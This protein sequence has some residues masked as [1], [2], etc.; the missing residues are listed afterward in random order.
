MRQL[1]KTGL[2]YFIN[3]TF[4]FSLTACFDAERNNPFD[5]KSDTYNGGGTGGVL[6][7]EWIQVS[8]A[9]VD[10]GDVAINDAIGASETITIT[11]ISA[12]G[13][14]LVIN[15]MT[16]DNS[17]GT[18]FTHNAALTATSIEPG[19]SESFDVN[20]APITAG[21]FSA[22]LIINSND[23]ALPAAEI[24]MKG[25]GI[26]GPSFTGSF[27]INPT[28]LNF[29]DTVAGVTSAQIQIQIN[30]TT[31]SNITIDSSV[32]AGSAF[33]PN[34]VSMGIPANG[35]IVIFVTFTPPAADYY[36]DYLTLT[37]NGDPDD[38]LTI[39][40]TGTG[41]STFSPAISSV[42]FE[43]VEINT[44]ES[45]SITITNNTESALSIS[46]STNS[47]FTL[48]WINTSIPAAGSTPIVVSF[49]PTSTGTYNDVITL[50]AG[51]ISMDISLYGSS[52]DTIFYVKTVSD[53]GSNGYAGTI[54]A[55]FATIDYA[56]AEANSSAT[57][58]IIKV[59]SGD[60]YTSS[61]IQLA[62]VRL[63]GGYD[64]AT[65]LESTRS[66]MSSA[67]SDSRTT[68]CSTT[69]NT[70][71]AVFVIN[72]DP[73]N[74]TII[75]GFTITGASIP[76][77]NPVS[78]GVAIRINTFNTHGYTAAIRNNDISGGTNNQT[79][80]TGQDT[81]ASVCAIFHRNTDID[82]QTRTITIERNFIFGGSASHSVRC[83]STCGIAI[84]NYDA[85]DS[86]T[87]FN[88]WNNVIR[89][90]QASTSGTEQIVTT[91][92]I[93]MSR[94]S[95]KIFNNTI[96]IGYCSSSDS[97]YEYSYVIGCYLDS[98]PEI[99][100]NI[101]LGQTDSNTIQYGIYEGD[102]DADPVYVRNNCFYNIT[103]SNYYYDVDT[104]GVKP[105]ID[106]DGRLN[107][108]L[109]YIS[110]MT[111]GNDIDNI[112]IY[113]D[114]LGNW[115]LQSSSPAELRTHGLDIYEST[116][117]DGTYRID[118]DNYMRSGNA[119]DEYGW[120]MGAF[121]Y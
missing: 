8:P 86:N 21:S 55:P 66:L 107:L 48:N 93:S 109:S 59:A 17:S 100:N 120:S 60:Y 44:T 64:S 105:A 85:D 45:E 14:S 12:D 72:G 6:T 75:D 18:T 81:Y 57:K 53:G 69:Q 25:T 70:P 95:P 79:T 40:L 4:L 19:T 26:A 97:F 47:P 112:S 84:S 31:D 83:A 41:T 116:G 27:S 65:F 121:E 91:Y 63:Y 20:F 58:K 76:S 37:A 118:K 71:S 29:P 28:S 54:S 56:V 7:G 103:S 108:A 2:V 73:G 67:I 119:G 80:D 34:W 22:T 94:V 46:A 117:V 99:I 88:I 35:N 101:I 113:P 49:N 42:T 52:V 87:S 15:D 96:Q 43:N 106:G 38:S 36:S 82:A 13:E 110:P 39:P 5:P 92:S 114:L 98:D 11:N 89:A 90:G 33:A 10:F 51:S 1:F 104:G 23:P 78:Y 30:N 61:D 50:T 68:T 74:E 16:I 77:T 111:A 115:K 3:F 102:T 24:D 9:S 32:S 62:G